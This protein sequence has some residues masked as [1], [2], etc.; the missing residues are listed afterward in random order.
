MMARGNGNLKNKK[1]QFNDFCDSG[2]LN[3]SKNWKIK[4]AL[5]VGKRRRRPRSENRIKINKLIERLQFEFLF[6]LLNYCDRSRLHRVGAQF[7]RH[8][9]LHKKSLNGFNMKVQ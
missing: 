5:M 1:F 3:K 7:P 6:T 9:R 2:G 8:Q 4:I